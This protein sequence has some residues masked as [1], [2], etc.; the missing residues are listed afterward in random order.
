MKGKV[1][2]VIM[3]TALISCRNV[4]ED[5]PV[6]MARGLSTGIQHPAFI[7]DI[8]DYKTRTEQLLA[9]N[10]AVMRTFKCR[11]EVEH[12]QSNPYY[13]HRIAELEKKNREMKKKIREYSANRKKEWTKFKEEFT[14]ELANLGESYRDL[15]IRNTHPEI[16][17]K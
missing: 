3:F 14:A 6:R 2:L 15:A 7:S 13:K 17:C 1:I 9:Q 12:K 11:L 16:V 4:G 8:R 10:D 5:Q